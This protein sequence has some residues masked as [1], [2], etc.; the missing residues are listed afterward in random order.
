MFFS[1]VIPSHKRKKMLSD[2]LKSLENQ[3]FK[4]FEVIVVPTENDPAFEL[5]NQTWPFQLRMEFI[6]NDPTKGKSASAKRNFGAALASAPWIAFIDDDCLADSQWL[7]SA[8][9]KLK[10][11]N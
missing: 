8:H 3:S 9:L 11:S 6:P 1:V 10:D 2:L 5:L 4:N 7:E